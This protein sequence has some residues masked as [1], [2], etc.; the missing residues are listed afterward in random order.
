MSLII[1]RMCCCFK[2]SFRSPRTHTQ[3]PNI[4]SEVE[5]RTYTY[6]KTSLYRLTLCDVHIWMHKYWPSV[7][8]NAHVVYLQ[9]SKQKPQGSYRIFFGRSWVKSF[10]HLSTQFLNVYVQKVNFVLKL[11]VSNWQ[12]WSRFVHESSPAVPWASAEM[13]R[14]DDRERAPAHCLWKNWIY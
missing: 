6:S 9:T 11:F 10:W 4:D 8:S 2:I 3:F 13:C 14:S 1:C 12:V 7:K 5:V